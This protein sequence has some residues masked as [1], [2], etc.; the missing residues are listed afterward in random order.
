MSELT[1]SD[2][3]E[4]TTTS[5]F[6]LSSGKFNLRME[7]VSERVQLLAVQGVIAIGLA[8]TGVYALSVAKRPSSNDENLPE[9]S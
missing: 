2:D 8:L 3:A 5:K 9:D 1:G 6:E 7:N 4:P